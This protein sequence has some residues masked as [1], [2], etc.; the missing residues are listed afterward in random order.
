M[1][2]VLQ[3]ILSNLPGAEWPVCLR[4]GHWGARDALLNSKG[5]DVSS[6]SSDQA[7]VF[8]QL[9]KNIENACIKARK[10]KLA[11]QRVVIF[12]RTQQFRDTGLTGE[13]ILVLWAHRS[14]HSG[15]GSVHSGGDGRR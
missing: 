8:A 14:R 7:F 13:S 12:L 2:S 9:G 11:A 5:E 1:K 6:A 4:A 15:R 3:T 10:Y